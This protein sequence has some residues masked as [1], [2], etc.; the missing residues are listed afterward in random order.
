MNETGKSTMS[1]ERKLPCI[2]PLAAGLVVL[3]VIYIL[4]LG[5]ACWLSSRF[6]GE[7]YV[8]IAYRPVTFVAEVTDS[9]RG[10]KC[11]TRMAGQ[12]LAR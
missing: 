7:R 3:P 1:D 11:R 8:S 12:K 9:N 2:G 6:G 10:I 5:P 4:S